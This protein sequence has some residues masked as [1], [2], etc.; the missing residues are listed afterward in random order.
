MY[1]GDGN[2]VIEIKESRPNSENKG[3]RGEESEGLIMIQERI[4][5]VDIVIN[6][7]RVICDKE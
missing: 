7:R 5:C 1:F 2:G 3:N 6:L 4:S